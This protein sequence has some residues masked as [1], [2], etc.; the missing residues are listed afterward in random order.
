MNEGHAFLRGLTGVVGFRTARAS[1][2]TAIR[3][4]SGKTKY[5]PFFGSLRI[6]FT[7][8]IAFSDYLLN[9]MV[10]VGFV[11][12]LIAVLGICLVVY[13]KISGV[14]GFA[15]G[16]PTVAI[17]MLFLSGIQ[18]IGMGVLGTYV[19]ASL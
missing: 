16:L 17:M 7:G 18:F 5:N 6:G 9:L 4:V 13:L 2:S 11:T 19:A 1:R 12:A 3:R 8:I 14:I 15:A 10:W